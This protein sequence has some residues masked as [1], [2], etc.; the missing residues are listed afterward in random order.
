M[1]KFGKI[2]I[3]NE[4]N[5]KRFN[6]IDISL[7]VGTLLLATCVFGGSMWY[8]GVEWRRRSR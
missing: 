5:I 4:T 2:P 6:V 1:G 7:I 3:E 8:A